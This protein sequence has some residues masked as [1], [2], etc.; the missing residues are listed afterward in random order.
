MRTTDC[1]Q[2]ACLMNRAVNELCPA[3]IRQLRQ[4]A[5]RYTLPCRRRPNS[6]TRYGQLTSISN[7]LLTGCSGLAMSTPVAVPEIL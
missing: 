2:G 4:S 6:M 3:H 7:G 5:V 1:Y